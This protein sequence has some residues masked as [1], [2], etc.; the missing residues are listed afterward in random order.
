MVS[1]RQHDEMPA[2][3]ARKVRGGDD[4]P[5]WLRQLAAET[6]PARLLRA[7]AEFERRQDRRRQGFDMYGHPVSAARK[8]AAW[9]AYERLRAEHYAQQGRETV[10]AGVA[11]ASASPLVRRLFGLDG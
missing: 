6:P 1:R 8:Q 5:A 9:A 10:P 11:F 3:L 2:W 7:R 4:P